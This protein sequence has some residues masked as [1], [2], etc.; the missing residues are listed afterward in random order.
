MLPENNLAISML[1][2]MKKIDDDI[3]SELEKMKLENRSGDDEKT[4]KQTRSTKTTTATTNTQTTAASNNSN[5]SRQ[6]IKIQNL[7]AYLK[8]TSS[9]MML[10]L[11]D[12]D[13]SN[14]FYRLPS[15]LSTSAKIITSLDTTTSTL[16]NKE[17]GNNVYEKL[18]DVT[19]TVVRP[20]ASNNTPAI[21]STISKLNDENGEVEVEIRKEQPT[22]AANIDSDKKNNSL[23]DF[24]T[25]NLDR[26]C[27]NLYISEH[28][29]L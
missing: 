1:N 21:I 11:M 28:G 27:Y 25:L 17:S 29:I 19:S 15:S 2:D 20:A 22:A 8:S 6:R 10:T 13:D 26:Y 12:E 7:D 5:S 23:Y 16:T 4:M 3:R 24:L 18:S 14:E 9:D